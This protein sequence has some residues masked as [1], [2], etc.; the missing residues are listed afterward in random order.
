M[1][2]E[3]RRDVQFAK[4][5]ENLCRAAFANKKVLT[6]FQLKVFTEARKAGKI[7]LAKAT[8]WKEMAQVPTYLSH[9]DG[10]AVV[11]DEDD[12]THIVMLYLPGFAKKATQSGLVQNMHALMDEQSLKWDDKRRGGDSRAGPSSHA[13]SATLVPP[14]Q[15]HRVQSAPTLVGPRR[16]ARLEAKRAANITADREETMENHGVEVVV[17]KIQPI[18]EPPFKTPDE[19]PERDSDDELPAALVELRGGSWHLS[20]GWFQRGQHRRLPLQPSADLQAGSNNDQV[21]AAKTH[22]FGWKSPLD[23]RINHVVDWW[24]PTFYESVTRCKQHILDAVRPPPPQEV[25][26]KWESIY[27]HLALGYNRATH[28]HRDCGGVVHGLD[29]LLLT[30][31]FAGSTLVLP[32]VN[33]HAEWAPGDFCAFDGKLFTH[34]V[35]PWQGKER[36]CFIYF[37]KRNI[38]EHFGLPSPLEPP[39]LD[40]VKI[41]DF[42]TSTNLLDV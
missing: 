25:V 11:V 27:P 14:Q 26:E 6:G 15:I 8:Q 2:H 22:V 34:E 13:P 3:H 17:E 5:D 1:G 37:V 30:G 7:P 36:M 42:R 31:D 28:R 29:C 19:E 21:M 41:P 32:D 4:G 23:K 39:R 38:F 33:V 20:L 40:Q 9:E 16:S 35:E 18:P 12:P 10:P 24:F